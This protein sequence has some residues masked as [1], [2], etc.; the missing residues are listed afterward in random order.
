MSARTVS[1]LVGLLL[2]LA[3]GAALSIEQP[4]YTVVATVGDI[5]YRQYEPY[6]VAETEVTGMDDYNDAAN[7]GFR[8]L[9]DYISGANASQAKIAMTA[10]VQQVAGEKIAMTAPV[11]QQALGG[12]WLINFM[13]PGAYDFQTVPQPSDPRI[14]IR[15][16]PGGLMAVLRYSGRWT[17]ANFNRHRDELLLGLERAGTAPAGGVTSAV[18]NPPFM[19]PFLR[20]NEIMVPVA[21]L[22][23]AE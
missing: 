10:P 18:Y 19:P 6:L 22:P 16:V 5:E 14:R 7:E 21:S 13:V 15:E 4:S 12:G 11:Q 23:A 17:D 3:A 8:R 2:C 9:F 20:R 1:Q